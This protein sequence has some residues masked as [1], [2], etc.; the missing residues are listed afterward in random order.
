MDQLIQ[1]VRE[2]LCDTWGLVFAFS[3]THECLQEHEPA[4]ID[5]LLLD[6]IFVKRPE[7]EPIDI[8]NLEVLVRH[9]TLDAEVRK[10]DLRHVWEC[11]LGSKFYVDIL[12][13]EEV[14]REHALGSSSIL[15]ALDE[16]V[17]LP[18]V[19]IVVKTFITGLVGINLPLRK[20]TDLLLEHSL[21]SS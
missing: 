1:C 2:S 9:V 5:L 4:Y 6:V 19:C 17:Q 14:F 18:V 10:S 20:D 13:E 12:E 7:E 3:Y 11:S 15:E 8:A 21:Y 16:L